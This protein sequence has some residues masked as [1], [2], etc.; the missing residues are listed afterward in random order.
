[1]QTLAE[2]KS[3]LQNESLVPYECNLEDVVRRLKPFVEEK[4]L[5]HEAE[6]FARKQICMILGRTHSTKQELEF[7]RNYFKQK[8]RGKYVKLPINRKYCVNLQRSKALQIL[9][10]EGFLKMTRNRGSLG[11]GRKAK[12]WKPYGVH[13]TYLQLNENKGVQ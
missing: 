10:S 8:I 6:M 1:M 4:Y 7:Y 13:T 11:Y 2:I 12:G 3:E 5:P 9:L